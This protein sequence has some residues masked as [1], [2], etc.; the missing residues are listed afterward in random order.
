MADTVEVS[1][2]KFVREFPRMRS[3]ASSGKQITVAIKGA[4]FSFRATKPERPVLLGLMKGSMKINCTEEELF[5][6]GAKWEGDECNISGT[7]TR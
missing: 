6:T 2:R 1:A 5:S 3:L 7:R 4:R